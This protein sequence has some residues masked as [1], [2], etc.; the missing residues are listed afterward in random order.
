[1]SRAPRHA[2]RLLVVVATVAAMVVPAWIRPTRVIAVPRTLAR[3][4]HPGPRGHAALVFAPTHVAF[5]WTGREGSGVVYRTVGP[6]GVRSPW[7]SATE[8]HDLGDGDR[9]YSAVLVVD[10]PA[11]LRWRPRAG[12]GPVHDLRIDYLNTVDGPRRLVE[13]PALADARA[14]TPKIVTRAE[15]GADESIK[16]TRGGCKREFFPV[17]QLFVHHTAGSNNDPHPAATMRAIYWFHTVSRGWCDIG[18]NFVIGSDGRLF[19]GRWARDYRFWETHDSEDRYGD[20]VAGAHVADYNSGSLGVSLMGNY[21]K[22]RLPRSMRR[23][24]VR[25]LAWEADK[26]NLPPRSRHTYRNPE[27]GLRRRLP[28]IAGHRDAGYTDCP[29]GH[30][31]R[32]LPSIRRAVAARIGRGRRST[33]I[34]LHDVRKV[35]FGDSAVA[36]GVLRDGRGERL[37]NKNVVVFRKALESPWR[38]HRRVSTD[39]DGVFRVRIEPTRLTRLT[40]HFRGDR[41]HWESQSRDVAVRVAPRISL[42]AQGGTNVDGIEHFPAGTARV[43]LS[44]DVDPAHDGKTVVVRILATA[45]DGSETLVKRVAKTLRNGGAYAATLDDPAPEVV[46]RAVATFDGDRDHAAGTSPSVLFT[47]DA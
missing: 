11:A 22:A 37:R 12:G 28:Y 31:Y 5:S 16:R 46:Y 14:T 19:E 47:V 3:T 42:R 20:A 15:W 25:V 1:M 9:H 2:V 6:A 44:G 32:A 38:R 30:V 26:H 13:V 4:L 45:A 10:G 21:S 36:T 41:R 7:R 29:G 24:L 43:P 17:Q 35:T 27:T 40:A 18:Y 34:S 8:A 23:K 39:R 33:T